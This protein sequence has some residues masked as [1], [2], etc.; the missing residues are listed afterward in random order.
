MG[1]LEQLAKKEKF[2]ISRV[3]LDMFGLCEEC[4]VKEP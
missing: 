3:H 2:R 1:D 4:A